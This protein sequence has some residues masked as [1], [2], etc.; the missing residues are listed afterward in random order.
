MANAPGASAN[1]VQA[2][3]TEMLE[4]LKARAPNL[5]PNVT[6]RPFKHAVSSNLLTLCQT[7]EHRAAV[8]AFLV[9]RLGTE[10]EDVQLADGGRAGG[11][12]SRQG[13]GV[14]GHIVLDTEVDVSARIF[15]IT[16]AKVGA[17]MGD[18]V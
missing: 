3:V 16:G 9:K 15:R 8:Q 11:A 18:H 4:L 10:H 6:P 12:S 5:R 1:A 7:A 2:R 14:R 13:E 17:T